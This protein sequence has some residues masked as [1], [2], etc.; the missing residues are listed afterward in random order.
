MF[1]PFH[2]PG[3]TFQVMA[4]DVPKAR[5]DTVLV[6]PAQTVGVD[7]DTDNPG[8]WIT[9]CHN[10]YHL[11]TG[12]RSSSSMPAESYF[13]ATWPT[14]RRRTSVASPT[15]A[16]RRNWPRDRPDSRCRHRGCCR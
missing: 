11:E 10:T 16:A 14:R 1:H 8:R 4:A 5:N 9:Y 6:P 3:H 2:P 12:W 13:G 7:F 15:S